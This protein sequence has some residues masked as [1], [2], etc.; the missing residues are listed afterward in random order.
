MKA[1]D[2]ELKNLRLISTK[3]ALGGEIAQ[4]EGIITNHQREVRERAHYYFLLVLG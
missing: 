3:N 4:K 2:T 1:M